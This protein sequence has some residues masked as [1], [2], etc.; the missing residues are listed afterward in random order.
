LHCSSIR[1]PLASSLISTIL[2]SPLYATCGG[3]GGGGMGG[4]ASGDQAT[5]Y[6]VPWVFVEKVAAPPGDLLVYW[7]PTGPEDAQHSSLRTSRNLVNWSAHCVGVAL[8]PDSNADLR[9]KFLIEGSQS[10]V[11]VATR[12]GAEIGRVAAPGGKL[13]VRDV[14]KIVAAELKTREAGHASALKNATQVE[15]S[16]DADA[17]AEL[18]RQVAGD[19]CLFP[20][21][22]KK[23]NKRSI[24][25]AR[26]VPVLPLQLYP[27][28]MHRR[29]TSARG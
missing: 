25:W 14:E 18:Y 19:G 22:A 10:A 15:K 7:F 28:R 17:A 5:V 8:V 11:V 13:A 24:A 26:P 23:A 2:V 9:Q 21:L 27:R 16:G 3:G 20:G 29:P 1:K 4:I 12:Q 6:Y